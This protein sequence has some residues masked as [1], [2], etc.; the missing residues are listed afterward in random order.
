MSIPSTRRRLGVRHVTTGAWTHGGTRRQN[1]RLRAATEWRS[2]AEL[3][4]PE[5][6]GLPVRG[7][8]CQ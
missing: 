5:S 1:L 2:R 3:A 7:F 4:L 8:R 6:L